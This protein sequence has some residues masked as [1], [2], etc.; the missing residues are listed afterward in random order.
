MNKFVAGGAFVITYPTTVTA[1]STMSPCDVIYNS[2]T[3]QMGCTVD[4]TART[5]S[6]LTGFTEAVAKGESI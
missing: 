2:V 5:I 4:T 1:A 3:Y 6:V